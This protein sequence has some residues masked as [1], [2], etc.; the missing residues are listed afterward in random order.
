M[1]SCYTLPLERAFTRVMA[2]ARSIM[3]LFGDLAKE[4]WAVWKREMSIAIACCA[5]GLALPAS[6]QEFPRELIAFVYADGGGVKLGTTPTTPNSSGD[7]LPKSDS[8]VRGLYWEHRLPRRLSVEVDALYFPSLYRNAGRGGF[9]WQFP[10]LLKAGPHLGPV[11]PYVEGGPYF[12]HLSLV[13]D[14]NYGATF[15]AGI[16]IRVRAGRIA[17]EIRYNDVGPFKSINNQAEFLLGLGFG[18]K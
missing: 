16:E 2:T 8:V 12:S 14:F 18:R 13:D 4:F 9:V 10:V 17:P 15:G 3:R 1:R 7:W 6:A 11:R 5:C